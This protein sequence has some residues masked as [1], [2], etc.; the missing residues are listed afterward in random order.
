M[1]LNLVVDRLDAHYDAT[2]SCGY[3]DLQLIVVLPGSGILAELQLHLR[4]IM[5]VK[6]GGGGGHAAYVQYRTKKEQFEFLNSNRGS[7]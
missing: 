4:R 2:E 6:S 5:E 3:R 1:L 7:I